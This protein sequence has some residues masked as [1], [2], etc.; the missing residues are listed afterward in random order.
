MTYSIGSW[1]PKASSFAAGAAK[2]SWPP[3]SPAFAALGGSKAAAA[4]LP[5][6]KYEPL[7]SSGG[8]GGATTTARSS[9]GGDEPHGGLDAEAAAKVIAR[10]KAI[11]T[12]PQT[13]EAYSAAHELQA[14]MNTAVNALARERPADPMAALASL[15]PSATR[16]T[17]SLPTA[18]TED[19]LEMQQYWRR[20]HA[21]QEG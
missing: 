17:A 15:L 8:A 4:P 12:S 19:M 11:M 3:A 20:L 5:K 16:P 1:P 9:Y 13:L 14:M 18:A 7:P 6:V 10:A 2:I 21:M